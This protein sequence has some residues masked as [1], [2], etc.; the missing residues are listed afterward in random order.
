MS[1][2]FLSGFASSLH[3]LNG[4]FRG[5]NIYNFSEIQ[6]TSFFFSFMDCAL[7]ALTKLTILAGMHA[8]IA[9]MQ[10]HTLTQTHTSSMFFI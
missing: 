2:C 1:N 7:G 8:H 9:H 4:A 5:A 3:P 10:V 6:L